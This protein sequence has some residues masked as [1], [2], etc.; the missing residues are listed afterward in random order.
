MSN[1]KKLYDMKTKRYYYVLFIFLNT[2]SA[3]GQEI[4]ATNPPM[5]LIPAGEFIMG[6]D[7]EKGYDFSPAHKV[8]VNSIYMDRHEVTNG[9][10]L[11]FCEATNH[12]LPEFWNSSIFKNGEDFLN[13]PVIGI[14]W[15]EAKKYA[16]WSGKRLPT[17]AEWEY[18]ARGGLIDKEYPNG[19]EW[20]K[21]RAKQDSKGWKNL[22][23]P[24]EK[25]EP[26][27]FGLYDMGGNVWEWVSD[28]YSA[29][30]YEE[31]KV[32]NPVGPDEGSNRVIRS[33]SWH[34]GAMCKR[35]YYRKAL[36]ANWCDFAVGFRCVKDLK[37]RSK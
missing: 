31:S 33:G 7:S 6:K 8:K 24:V 20:I 36:P 15:G 3:I 22:I 14:N 21:E 30:Y 25:Y 13:Y 19:D 17:E 11:R 35:V 34:S 1:P 26:N 37:T 2:F 23:D 12:K 28:R 29:T 4:N 9:E 16:E 27:G 32:D 10:Y 18:A 5:V